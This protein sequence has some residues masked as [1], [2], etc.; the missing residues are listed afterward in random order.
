MAEKCV[1]R[2]PL[3]RDGVSR[4]Q[5]FLKALDP[6]QAPLMEMSVK[7]WMEFAYDYAAE[8]NFYDAQNPENPPGDWQDFFPQKGEELDL[9]FSK[10]ENNQ[11]HEP[12][13]AL[14]LTF[15]KL[16]E[17]S[18]DRMNALTGAHLDFY[19]K[20]VLQLR[21]KP[22]TPDKVHVIFELAKNALEEKVEN[23]AIL[24]AGNDK[25]GKKLSYKTT[26]EL[27]VNSAQIARLC[28]IAR[29]K[30]NFIRYAAQ[31]NSKDGLGE[32]LPKDDPKWSAFGNA[33]LPA[34]R[35]GFAFGSPVL[36]MKEGE[37]TVAVF[38]KL[39]DFNAGSISETQLQSGLECY[40][41]GEKGWL[42]P[43]DFQADLFRQYSGLS[44]GIG[45]QYLKMAFHLPSSE[46]A[47][48]NYDPAI[49]GQ[50]FNTTAPVMRIFFKSNADGKALFEKIEAATLQETVIKVKVEGMKEL[51]L[52]NDLGRLDASKPF[53]PFGAQPVV[54]S[55][56]FIGSKEVF[57]KNWTNF[58]VHLNWMEL[59]EK[60]SDHYT[61][62]TAPFRTNLSKK[63]YNQVIKSTA[64]E[65]SST[66]RS[67]S[68]VTVDD[69]A[70]GVPLQLQ[71]LA[72]PWLGI[73]QLY[74]VDDRIV[75]SDDYF[76]ADIEVL[77]DK[78]WKNKTRIHL[79]QD[80]ATPQYV[81]SEGKLLRTY[82][83]EKNNQVSRREW[84][85]RFEEN[86]NKKAHLL[87]Y[88][89]GKTDEATSAFDYKIYREQPA[90]DFDTNEN[91][92]TKAQRGFL[93]FTL[94]RDFLHKMYPHLYAVAISKGEESGAL[95]P[96]PPYTPLIEY[97]T[98][99]Y[100]AQA[101]KNF[102]IAAQSAAN[103]WA[104][105][106]DGE[107]LFFQEHPFGQREEHIFLKEQFRFFSGDE[108]ISKTRLRLLPPF[109]YRGEF[110]VGL[111]ARAL[112][113]LSLLLQ[114][115]EGSENPLAPV[116]EQGDKIDWWVL[117]GN[118]WRLLTKNH[119]VKNTTDNFFN[120][121]ILKT[122]LPRESA[123][124]HTILEPGLIWLR[125]TLPLKFQFDSTP[126]LVGVFAQAAEA[127]FENNDNEL[128]H[129]LTALP[130]GAIAKMEQMPALIKKIAQPFSSFDGRPE[131]SDMAFYLRVS[132]RLRHKD[133][134]VNI[135]DYE[136]L[137]LE[138]FPEV[139][140][141][142]CL[143]HTSLEPYS[144]MAPGHVALIGL[145]DLRNKNLPDRLQ[146]R[147]S[148]RSLRRIEAYLRN[149]AGKLVQVDATNPDYE[150]V[151]M[152]LEV[153]FYEGFDPNFYK[154]QLNEDLK[155]YLA[156][157]TADEQMEIHFGGAIYKTQVIHFM[158]NLDYVDFVQNVKMYH[159]LKGEDCNVLA[160][161]ISLSKVEPASAISILTSC[162]QHIIIPKTKQEICT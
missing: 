3:R 138:A 96:N 151:K 23:G 58:N 33:D 149:R 50:T 66:T 16:L 117:A 116:F 161:K 52:E 132:E 88:L 104:D 127:V 24:K 38:L 94:N 71:F 31:V 159:F 124:F 105:F 76:T 8:L 108:E 46:P 129:L 44:A 25:D 136:H 65:E 113:L 86:E 157:W 123:G 121:G 139:Y 17:K 47:V 125:A 131:E 142:K 135:W 110:L 19:Y 98:L 56:F 36:K 89:E 97:A 6:S 70:T 126:K 100:E 29:D 120:S 80:A 83:I 109:A 48:T 140:K 160:S 147:L 107:L 75:Q 7:D 128:S 43:I 81:L 57:E 12:H 18:K 37:R 34:A 156:P 1:D 146:P 99:D 114:N 15:L 73:Y 63:T 148:E 103:K 95:I 61:A 9:F 91:L 68:R 155:K 79:M 85:R 101:H 62:Y 55:G 162:E 158:E 143:N 153:I 111:K 118:E 40:F 82:S 49:H 32:P 141:V 13:I 54:G 30:N 84:E 92:S 67:L 2:N 133:R 102:Q 14:F 21:K 152:Q 39:A 51:H 4:M 145:P 45:A 150:V 119:V 78:K 5:R 122:V 137:V 154:N 64:P 87:N 35:F 41:S 22:A 93:K 74:I 130:A 60:L 26:E 53:L 59:P 72:Q 112:Q 11:S 20:K 27:I 144:E 42:G 77:D 134:A 28:C 106:E 90:S 115:A 69:A 10:I